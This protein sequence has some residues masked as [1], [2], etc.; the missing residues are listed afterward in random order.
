MKLGIYTSPIVDTME[1][2]LHNFQPAFM[3]YNSVNPGKQRWGAQGI[4][5]PIRDEKNPKF[6]HPTTDWMLIVILAEDLAPWNE[7]P[8]LTNLCT[9]MEVPGNEITSGIFDSIRPKLNQ[10][11]ADELMALQSLMDHT[12]IDRSDLK[13][14]DNLD[15]PLDRIGKFFRSDLDF[16]KEIQMR[17]GPKK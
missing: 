10:V 4:S 12:S 17:I 1:G 7:C 15:I 8:D 6:G 16:K 3:A 14:S 11:K 5:E 13:A 9:S 2:G